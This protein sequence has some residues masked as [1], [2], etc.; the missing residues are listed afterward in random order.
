MGVLKS[1]QN[2]RV[3]AELEWPS[4]VQR[5]ACGTDGSGFEPRT[6]TNAS[7]HVCKY[8]DQKGLAAM[9]TSIQSAG[10]TPEVNLIITQVRTQGIHPGFET[11][12]TRAEWVRH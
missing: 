12:G 6:T 8:V 10:V 11:Q 3:A 4:G 5:R 2:Q 9:L 1:E 7:R